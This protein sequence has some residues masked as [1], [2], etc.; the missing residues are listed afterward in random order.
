RDRD[1]QKAGL[2]AVLPARP[3]RLAAARALGLVEVARA[4]PRP[5]EAG[6]VLVEHQPPAEAEVLG[7]GAQEPLDVG[8]PRHDAE[9]LLLERPQVLPPDLRRL[10]AV[11]DV[12]AAPQARLAEGVP[13]LEHA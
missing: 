1:R 9:L 6:L 11:G 7:V 3:G 10:L 8:R 5:F 4:L 2:R 13:D 12:Q